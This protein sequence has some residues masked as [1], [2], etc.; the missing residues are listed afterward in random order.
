MAPKPRERDF[1]SVKKKDLQ[2]EDVVKYK[3]KTI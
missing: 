3:W 1:M 2:Y